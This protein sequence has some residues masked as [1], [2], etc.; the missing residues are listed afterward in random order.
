MSV[1][2]FIFNSRT[3]RQTVEDLIGMTQFS[4]IANPCGN[5]L[6]PEITES[7][8]K[9]RARKPGPLQI[10]FLGNLTP[11]KGL[12]VLLDALPGIPENSYLLTVI[13]DLTMD[14]AYSQSIRNQIRKLNLTDNVLITGPI[15]N[16]EL[17]FRLKESH[18]LVVPSF[19]EGYGIAY[20]EGM[21]FGLPAIA[22]TAGAA[23][24]IITTVRMVS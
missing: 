13:G 11:N 18:I 10:V 17:A 24:E 6:H 8:I 1:D 16:S 3:T 2:G 14:R 19:Y 12:H 9:E 4:V 22:T 21:G 7:E 20:L 5:R 15:S 23:N